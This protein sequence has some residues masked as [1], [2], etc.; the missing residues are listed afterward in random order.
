LS[1]PALSREI[2]E[3]F[4]EKPLDFFRSGIYNNNR[5]SENEKEVTKMIKTE[6]REIIEILEELK[7]AIYKAINEMEMEEEREN[8]ENPGANK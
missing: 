7:E 4:L 8:A 6:I 3:K 5:K 1:K 2:F